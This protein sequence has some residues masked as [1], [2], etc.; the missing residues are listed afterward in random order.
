MNP[1]VKQFNVRPVL[2]RAYCPD[3]DVELEKSSVA[4]LSNS[5]QFQYFC[6]QCGY[7]FTSFEQ[8]PKI[9]YVEV[10][11]DVQQA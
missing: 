11:E 2:S 7:G 8:Y 5:P 3:C 1:I 10:E 6:P 9:D 4:L